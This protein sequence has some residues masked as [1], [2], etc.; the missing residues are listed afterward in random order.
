[1][2]STAVYA[3]KFIGDKDFTSLA[4]H[5]QLWD[6][7]DFKGLCYFTPEERTHMIKGEVT[8][9]SGVGFKFRSDGYAPGEWEFKALT[10]D[11]FRK[12]YHK[13]MIEGEKIAQIVRST[14][15]LYN[16]FNTNYP[17]P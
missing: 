13:L 7:P 16:W 5:C 10:L 2:N 8:K 15:E 11:N 17:A 14:E 3:I 1:M 4:C 6:N 12:E 9:E